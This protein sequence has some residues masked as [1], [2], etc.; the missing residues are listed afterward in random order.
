MLKRS[1][2]SKC[3]VAR[4][5]GEVSTKKRKIMWP[6]RCAPVLKYFVVQAGNS[7][8]AFKAD[9]MHVS[10]LKLAIVGVLMPRKSANLQIWAF[11]FFLN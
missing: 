6:H 4:E 2:N 11:F 9:C 3:K 5:S 10:S 1:W 7:E 8:L